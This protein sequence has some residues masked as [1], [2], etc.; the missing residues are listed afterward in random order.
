MPESA[1]VAMVVGLTSALGA[2]INGI[3]NYFSN[4]RQMAQ[5]EQSAERMATRETQASHAEWLR[6]QRLEAY[7]GMTNALS[8]LLRLVPM[9]LRNSPQPLPQDARAGMLK[10][11]T[12]NSRRYRSLMILGPKECAVALNDLAASVVSGA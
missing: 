12:A 8:E 2:A 4:R 6:E 5:F 3:W 10:W 1:W 9:D 7:I 11:F